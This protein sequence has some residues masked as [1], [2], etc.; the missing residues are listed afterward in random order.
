MM[1][2]SIALLA[3]VTLQRL[4]ELALARRNTAA[5]L[6]RGAREVGAE[7]YPYMVALH[8]AWIGGLWLLAI[9]QA[10]EPLLV[11]HLHAAAGASPLGACD[12]QGA[13]DD[14]YHCPARARRSSAAD[15]IAS[16]GIRIM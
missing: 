11:R 2:A 3:F 14:A 7:H 8:A 4:G 12:A 6:A 5:L 9:E 10:G 1:L 15:P 13:M 16:S